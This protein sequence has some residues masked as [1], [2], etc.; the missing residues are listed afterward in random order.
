MYVG[1]SMYT[2][3][4]LK[5]MKILILHDSFLLRIRFVLH[6]Q[7]TKLFLDLLSKF[8]NWREVATSGGNVL[9]MQ[10]SKN[11]FQKTFK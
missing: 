7:I 5:I 2:Q 1:A 6:K 8:Q 11:A 4:D 9:R 3:M 10:Y